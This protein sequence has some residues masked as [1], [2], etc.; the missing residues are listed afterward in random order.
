MIG[1]LPWRLTAERERDPE[2]FRTQ[3]YD[4]RRDEMSLDEVERVRSNDNVLI[5]EIA[6]TYNVV[7]RTISRL[8]P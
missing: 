2:S 6:R 4:R 5:R 8:I 1:N 7:H 3:I